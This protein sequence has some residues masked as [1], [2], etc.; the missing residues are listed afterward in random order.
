MQ[1][2]RDLGVFRA[3]VEDISG[4]TTE[5]TALTQRML[6]RA[7]E[8]LAFSRQL[9]ETEPPKVWHPQPPKRQ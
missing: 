7:R 9:L 3:Y 2:A 8:Q 5:G 4:R 6:A 1:V